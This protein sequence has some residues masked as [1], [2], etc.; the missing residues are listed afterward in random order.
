MTA[1]T[2]QNEL[3]T[4]AMGEFVA[5]NFDRAIDLLTRVLEDDPA[6]RLALTTRGSA[7]MNIADHRAAIAD[8]TRAIEI[9]PESA[10]AFHLRGLA[11]QGAEAVDDALADFDRAIALD[12]EYGAAYF[13]RANLHEQRGDLDAAGEDIA[14]VAGLTRK[15]AEVFGN[16]NNVWQSDQI[17]VEGALETELDR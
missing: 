11:H 5:R 6:D 1:H 15:N 13:S 12:P 3:F 7:F 16:E 10:R 2:T 4:E 9:E 17:R 14:V 8:F